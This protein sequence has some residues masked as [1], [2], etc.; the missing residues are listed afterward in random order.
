M[1]VKRDYYEVLGLGRDASDDDIKKAFRKLAFQYHP[2]RN[3]E[4][5]AEEK[6][7]ELN[8]AYEVLASA[9]KRAVYDRFGHRAGEGW[10]ADKGNAEYGFGGLGDI[11]ETFFGGVA[12]S[13]KQGPRQGTDIN[14]E[15]NMSLED[16]A[17]G[18]DREIEIK[19]IES[20]STCKGSGS[21]A[22]TQPG[23]CPV[24]KGTGQ[25]RRAQRSI[26][27]SFVN[28]ATCDRCEGEGA[29]IT[30]PCSKCNGTGRERQTRKMKVQIPA[31]IEDGSQIRLSGEG[32]SGKRGGP[33]GNAYI[34]IH[35]KEHPLFKREGDDIFLDLPINVAQAAL[36]YEVDVPTLNGKEKL[37]VPAGT[38]AGKVFRLKE[39][40][41]PHLQRSGSGD[42]LV[43]I[44]VLIPR[45]LSERQKRLMEELEQTLNESDSDGTDKGFFHKVKEAFKN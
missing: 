32:N 37:R 2:D 19:R 27:G 15:L 30:D 28:V 41:I 43:K 6:F 10:T 21:K 11:F 17:F 44:N 14:L 33:A 7:K 26:F 34:L 1:T 5:G 42:L 24:C 36:G 40:G 38:Q 16:A 23:R 8:E 18:S 3:K 4:S 39:K 35:I 25:V 20:C 31:G 13:A 12:S 22:G 29:I 45:N 9:E